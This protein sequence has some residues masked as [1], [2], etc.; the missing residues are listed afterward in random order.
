MT[1]REIDYSVRCP[2][3]GGYCHDL[4]AGCS[5]GWMPYDDA[6]PVLPVE[7]K[8]EAERVAVERMNEA[9]EKPPTLDLIGVINRTGD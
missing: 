7:A 4:D 3:C 2:N 5:C 8:R 1:E 9:L 6:P